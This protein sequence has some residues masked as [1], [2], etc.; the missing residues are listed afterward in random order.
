M[1][2][3]KPVRA[4]ETMRLKWVEKVRDLFSGQNWNRQ[5]P[6]AYLAQPATARF[7]YA[8]DR[9]CASAQTVAF[10]NQLTYI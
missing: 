1:W 5:C 9:V 4:D 3:P 2:S 7:R 8:T 10:R 6:A